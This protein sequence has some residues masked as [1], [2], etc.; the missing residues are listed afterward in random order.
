MRGLAGPLKQTR[1]GRAL[2]GAAKRRVIRNYVEFLPE[3]TGARALVAYLAW[4]LLPP[5]ALRDRIEYSNRGLA[6]DIPRALNEL[7]YSVD[8]VNFDNERWIPDRPY[9]LMIGHGGANFTRLTGLVGTSTTK[10]YFATGTYWREANRRSAERL[11]DI[12]R[13]TGYLLPP[14]RAVD[15]A[16]EAANRAADG[17]I[18][19]GNEAAAKT[20]GSFSRVERV[21]NA[22]FPVN[23]P[24]HLL[25][26]DFVSARREFLFFSGPGNVHKGLDR[27]LEAFEG[28]N[29][30]LHVCQRVSEPFARAFGRY[31]SG[32]P[33]VAVH[34]VL[35]M[36]SP[37]YRALVRRCGWVVH[38]TAS[39]GQP[40]SVI[41]CMAHGLVP[42]LPIEA[43]IDLEDFGVPLPDCGIPAIRSVCADASCEEPAGLRRRAERVLEAVGTRYSPEAFRNAF[44]Q[45]VVSIRDQA[46]HL[47]QE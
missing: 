25:D 28:T 44:K 10:I 1:L 23:P 34:G 7:G 6:Q 21:N 31:L 40:G 3:P 14:E 11:A 35:G 29:L 43:N 41:E 47:P 30:I 46:G 13:R 16:E 5:P 8:V 2:L 24:E 45:A 32:H 36:R 26:K 37:E 39:E 15:G 19:L 20:Y 27:L 4:P 18:C 42:I 9:D 38:P 33:N 17:I 12:A 22:A